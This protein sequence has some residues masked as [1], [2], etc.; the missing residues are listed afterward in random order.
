MAILPE[1]APDAEDAFERLADNA[2]REALEGDRPRIVDCRQGPEHL[3][4]VDRARAH[5]AAMGIADVEIAEVGPGLPDRRA[6]I[7]FLDVHVIGVE[8]HLHVRRA[9]APTIFHALRGRVEK[10]GFVAV[11][12]FHHQR[13]VACGGHLR[14]FA[15]DVDGHGDAGARGRP[16]VLLEGGM[17]DAAD[18]LAAE[19]TADADRILEPLPAARGLVR[20][21]AGDVGIGVEA[22][23]E[24]D[25]DAVR[26]ELAAREIDVDGVRLRRRRLDE[27]V[28][29]RGGLLD[30]TPALVM[31]PSGDPDEGVNA[32]LIHSSSSSSGACS[33]ETGAQRRADAPQTIILDREG[34]VSPA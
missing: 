16:D 22:E 17:E 11:H 27:I 33:R 32:Q 5:V 13:D 26:L 23:R 34:H 28:T 15:H 4:E 14:H 3:G 30:R 31:A 12:D 9:D 7:R 18:E 10:V 6:D 8:M 25:A 24:I 21:A 19:I 29:H 20:L 1:V 2:G